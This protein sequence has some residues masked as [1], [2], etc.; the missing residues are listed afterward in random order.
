M[1]L[2]T[3]SSLVP[4]T[5]A[6]QGKEVR[7]VVYAFSCGPLFR[8]SSGADFGMRIEDVLQ[9]PVHAVMPV[10]NANISHVFPE[11]LK[12][13]S[14][15]QW[16][17]LS[18]L[19]PVEPAGTDRWVYG[20]LVGIFSKFWPPF[21]GLDDSFTLLHNAPGFYILDNMFVKNMI[22][23][24]S[25][26]TDNMSW[27][28]QKVQMRLHLRPGSVADSTRGC[29]ICFPVNTDNSHWY[30]LVA[31]SDTSSLRVWDSSQLDAVAKGSRRTLLKKVVL[32]W[33]RFV[34][35]DFW[36]VQVPSCLPWLCWIRST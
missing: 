10:L 24:I 32:V 33:M 36:N 11:H 34:Q 13:A 15:L 12:G 22:S 3:T 23:L 30:G 14:T 9:H 16:D 6:A 19:P 5:A 27:H 26:F 7:S 21:A 25:G 18:P 31:A 1:R 28:N 4:L 35:E 8:N 2:H 17:T 29:T 20:E